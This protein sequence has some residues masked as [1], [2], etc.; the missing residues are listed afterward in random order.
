MSEHD[1]QLSISLYM[2]CLTI[3]D[4]DISI[5]RHIPYRYACIGSTDASYN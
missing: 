5:R 4:C 3:T 2:F 1:D